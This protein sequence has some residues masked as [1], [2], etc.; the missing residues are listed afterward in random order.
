MTAWDCRPDGTCRSRRDW[1]WRRRE[2]GLRGSI[3]MRVAGLRFGIAKVGERKLRLIFHIGSRTE[4]DCEC[5]E[6][7]ER[8]LSPSRR[9][10]IK[11]LLDEPSGK[12][13]RADCG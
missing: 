3:R 1:D 8:G 2:S 11:R 9:R 4:S 10:A 12:Y 5:G 6:W 7:A 13:S